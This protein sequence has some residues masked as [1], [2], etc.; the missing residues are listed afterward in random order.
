M[1]TSH[2]PSR[3]RH[4]AEDLLALNPAKLWAAATR[5]SPSFWCLSFYLMVE[6]VR[7]QSVWVAIDVLPWGQTA[8]AATLIALLLEVGLKR[9]LTELDG[10]LMFFTLVVFASLLGSQ[11]ADE[12]FR[13]LTVLYNWLLLYY[14]TVQIITT[15]PRFLIFFLTF[16]LWSL[17]MSQHG[18][19]TFVGRGFQFA[20]WGSTGGPGWFQNSGEFAIQMC[21]F[22]AMALS[23]IL[24]MRHRWPRW[25][26]WLLLALLPGTA[27]VS[28]VA[29]SSRGGQLGG[30]AVLLML[31]AQ[32]RHRHRWRGLA[33]V[34]VVLPALWFMMPVEQKARFEG[35]GTD[36]TS[37]SRLTY[38]EDG[39]EIMME[40]PL[41]GIGYE[42]WM[43]YYTSR[44]DAEGQLPHNIFV[45]AGA[46]LGF[47]GLGAFLM[48]IVLTFVTNART[49][50]LS[51]RCSEWGGFFRST[52]FGLDAALVGYLVSGFFVTVLFYPYFWMN[53]SFTSALYAVTSRHAAKPSGRRPTGNGQPTRRPRGSAALHPSAAPHK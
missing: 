32:S 37:V 30:V 46:E 18:T 12:G 44:Y 42:G 15:A 13:E 4:S 23:F 1:P 7:P 9:R 52:A 11:Y 38:W 47:L 25:Q 10:A 8:L 35:M 33:A 43:P 3:R 41:L 40:H 22:L 24:A 5:Q 36:G 49:R 14:L 29:T 50:R 45:E 51:K 26:T 39:I 19:R 27:L 31:L 21:I 28:L 16:L 53:L 2:S 48:L 20:D 34:L 17:K 6:Y